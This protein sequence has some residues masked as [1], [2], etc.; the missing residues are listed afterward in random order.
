[1]SDGRVTARRA[2]EALRAGVPNR[3]AVIALGSAHTHIEEQ[4]RRQL[5]DARAAGPAALSPPGSWSPATLAPA[6]PI[7]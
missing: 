6:S 4:F 1:M 3:E 2:I 7:S 5:A